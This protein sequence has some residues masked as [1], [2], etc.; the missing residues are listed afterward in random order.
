M[1]KIAIL[2]FVFFALVVTSCKSNKNEVIIG[3]AISLTGDNALQ[4][5]RGY[6]GMMLAVDLANEA[7]GI[8]GKKIKMVAED[9]QTSAKGAINAMTKLVRVNKVD[10]AISTG[11]IEFQAINDITL[12]EK[13]V[14]LAT[15]C[16]GMLE[17]NRSPYLFRYC[18]NEKIQDAILMQFVKEG[19]QADEVA[20]LYPNNLW[21]KEIEQY[22]EEGAK[23]AGVTINIKETYDP[24]SLDQKAVAT[25]LF[26][27]NPKIVCARGFGSGFEAALRYLSELGFKGTIIGDITISL[28][29]TINNT[30]GIAEGA[31]FVSVDLKPEG[32]EYTDMYRQLY[33]EKYGEESSVWDAL[34]FDTG[35]YLIEALRTADTKKISLKEAMFETQDVDLLLGDNQFEKSNDVK[36]EMSIFKIEN[37]APVLVQ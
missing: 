23:A 5:N 14:T 4:G 28:P 31:Y 10:G 9:T 26:N 1:K 21:G 34:G 19:M 8:N 15:I 2:F 35:R 24:N 29:G 25:K 27:Q 18:F 37:G 13:M 33:L 30:R 20:L 17:D 32:D 12:K 22:N 36:F 3:G 6:K 16:S 7:G 11:D